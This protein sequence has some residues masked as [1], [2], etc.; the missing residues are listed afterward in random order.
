MLR[1]SKELGGYYGGHWPRAHEGDNRNV[2]YT[3]TADGDALVLRVFECEPMGPG[4]D[5]IEAVD[6]R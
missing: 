4:P 5:Y 2:G 1:P 3:L 6:K